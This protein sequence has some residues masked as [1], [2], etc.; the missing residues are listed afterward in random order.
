MGTAVF[1]EKNACASKVNS[2]WLKSAVCVRLCECCGDE[3]LISIFIIHSFI[4]KINKQ[5]WG[6]KLAHSFTLVLMLNLKILMT[7][8]CWRAMFIVKNLLFFFFFTSFTF[9]SHNIHNL[10]TKCRAIQIQNWITLNCFARQKRYKMCQ[11]FTSHYTSIYVVYRMLIL[12]YSFY[13]YQ[14]LKFT[15][16]KSELVTHIL[17]MYLQKMMSFMDT[18]KSTKTWTFDPKIVGN[19]ADVNYTETHLLMYY[20]WRPSSICVPANIS[21]QIHTIDYDTWICLYITYKLYH[22]DDDDYCLG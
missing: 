20:T 19:K 11:L 18:N 3:P 14:T 6:E 2:Y 7:T 12:W 4:N 16:E 13:V 5:K 21:N 17:Q 15:H 8:F 10:Y 22:D 9:N 1:S